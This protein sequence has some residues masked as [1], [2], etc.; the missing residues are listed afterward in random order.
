MTSNLG[1]TG[2]SQTGAT[3]FEAEPIVGRTKLTTEDFTDL[4][5]GLP[6]NRHLLLRLG[7]WLAAIPLFWLISA[8]L[9]AHSGEPTHVTWLVALLPIAVVAGLAFAVWRDRGLV[10]NAGAK[11]R[12]ATAFE[13]RF[14][15]AGFS[16]GVEGRRVQ[17]AWSSLDRYVETPKAFGIYLAPKV[18]IVVPKRAFAESEQP[19]LRA[20]LVEF[21]PTR[22]LR[23][24]QVWRPSGRTVLLGLLLVCASLAVWYVVESK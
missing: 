17:H 14:D 21:I 7:L 15:S 6:Q 10:K 12:A 3:D 19:R 16:F 20:C 22:Q 4:W 1:A 5:A 18:V 11:L 8:V 24:A 9:N 2:G 13:F 23:D